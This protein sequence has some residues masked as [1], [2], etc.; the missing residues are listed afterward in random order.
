VPGV[1][2]L[3][4]DRDDLHGFV[5]GEV[6]IARGLKELRDRTC[7]ESL[8]EQHFL[9]DH[10]PHEANVRTHLAGQSE[11]PRLRLVVE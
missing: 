7:Q 11:Q 10:V 6:R 2:Q 4:G 8:L 3:R 5:Y 9:R 1:I